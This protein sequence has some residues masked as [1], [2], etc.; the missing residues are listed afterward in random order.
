MYC[1]TEKGIVYTEAIVVLPVLITLF[2]LTLYVPKVHYAGERL[3]SATRFYAIEKA[4]DKGGEVKKFYKVKG[5]KWTTGEQDK[6]GGDDKLKENIGKN[7][8][9]GG[10]FLS[11]FMEFLDKVMGTKKY[12]LSL[13]TYIPPLK[14]SVN[15]SDT[16]VIHYDSLDDESWRGWLMRAPGIVY[17]LV[18][19]FAGLKGA[20]GNFMKQITGADDYIGKAGERAKKEFNKRLNTSSQEEIL[21]GELK[22]KFDSINN[23][24]DAC[25]Q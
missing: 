16:L 6:E 19:L 22:N 15:L 14:T 12:S 23:E 21:P 20:S 18:R 24:G 3:V 10:E 25:P 1:F 5:E 17:V 11:L 9:E 4:R 2:V 7:T 8:G 13:Q